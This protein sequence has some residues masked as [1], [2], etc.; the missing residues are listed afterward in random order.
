MVPVPWLNFIGIS[1]QTHD[2]AQRTL[3]RLTRPTHFS[4][5]AGTVTKKSS[6]AKPDLGGITR[7]TK[8]LVPDHRGLDEAASLLKSGQ[9]VAFPTE[10]VYGLGADA[11]N[12]QA[13][14]A[15]YAA[16]GRPQFNPLIAHIA[17]HADAEREGRFNPLALELAKAFWP[18]PLTLVVPRSENGTVCDLTCAGLDSVGLRFPSHPIARALIEKAGRPIA[19]PSANR[20]GHISPTESDHV[21]SDLSGRIDALI[22]AYASPVGVESTIIACLDTTPRLLRH[23]G[24]TQ[25]EIFEKTGLRLHSMEGGAVIAPGMLDSHYAPDARVRLNAQSVT[26]AEAVLLF[27]PVSIE[28]AD[29]AKARLNLSPRGDLTEAAAHLYDY[30]RRLDRIGCQ[31]IAIAPIPDHGLGAAINDRLRRAAAP[32]S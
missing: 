3:R 25:E 26:A 10:T 6:P 2:K 31:A 22:E 30:L 20:S 29:H 19:A 27:G 21:W 17:D 18:G 24:I 11:T 13:I 4:T 7:D 1:T 8:R 16:K 23:G 9:L 28:G 15:L 32:R 5:D 12:P 14:A